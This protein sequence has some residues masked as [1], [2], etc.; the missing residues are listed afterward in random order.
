[1]LD[2]Y[3]LVFLTEI[4]TS[5]KIS[6]TGFSIIQHSAKKGHRGGVAFLI[7]PSLTKFISKIDRSYENVI[8][9]E[10][11]IMPNIVFVGCYIT[12][13]DSPYYDAAVFGYLQG[14][15]K[16]DGSKQFFIL[17]D[18]NSRVGTPTSLKCDD[19]YLQYVGCEDPNLN[20][21]GT[22]ILRLCEE[23]ELAVINNL[24][25]GDVH[26]KSNLSFRKKNN[27]ISEPDLLLVSNKSLDLLSS[28]RMLQYFEE[29][30]LY[31]D[32]GLLEAQINVDKLKI[33]TKLL[34][35]RANNLGQSLHERRQIKID[36]S[37]RLSECNR[38]NVVSYFMQNNPPNLVGTECIETV[39]NNFT[40]EVMEVLKKNR[41]RRVIEPS[42]W[43][44][45]AKW[46]RLLEGNDPKSIWKAINWEGDIN[47]TSTESPSDEEFRVHFEELLNPPN[48]HDDVIDVSDM[49]YIPILDDPITEKEVVE[50]ASECKESKSYIGITP[51]IFKVMPAL[52]ITF[53]TQMLNLIF[54]S[55]DLSYPIKWCFNKFIVLFKKGVRLNC[56]NYRGLSIGDSVSKLYAKIMSKRL[57]LWMFIDKCQ[58]GGQAL[59]GCLEHILAL[60]LIIDYAKNEK[61]KLFIV[62]VDFSKAYDRVPRK[63]LFDILKRLG[64]GRRFLGA[65]I[66]VYKK[67]VNILNSEYIRSTIGVKQGGPM[68]CLLFVIYL[69]VLAL[70]LKGVG[71]D[72]FLLDV[73]A[74]ML[75]DDT[76]LLAGSRKSMIK[77]FTILMKFCKKYGMLVNEI[78]TKLMVINGTK[79]D[80]EQF[81][82]ESVVVKHTISYIYLGSPFTE[83]GKIKDVIQ[84]HIKTRTADVNKFKIF[85]KKNET[86][87]YMYKRTVLLAMII[88]GLLYGCE[89]WLTAQSKDVEKLY[90]G[91]VKSL[92]GVRETTR[93]DTVLIEAGMQTIKDLIRTRTAAFVKKELLN[94]EGEDVTPLV[95]IFRICEGKNT[96]GYR[97][98]KDLLT[99][100]DIINNNDTS[101]LLRNF[102]N[103]TGT[104]AV[105][106]RSINP[107]LRVHPVYTT[108][109]YVS[110]RARLT[111]TKFRL[112]SHSLK[113]E[114]GRWS[115]INHEDRLCDCGEAVEDEFH[116]L[117]SCAKTED[118]RRKFG[119]DV[120]LYENVGAMMDT[121]DVKVLV[122]FVDCCMDKFK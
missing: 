120:R 62:F 92:L 38:E 40:S 81:T 44:N 78:K 119:I 32:H 1:M 91:A 47:E 45:E 35:E 65:L 53:I 93:T 7:K 89:T 117:F 33:S 67:T 26:F 49:P 106:Y 55:N 4:K 60:R 73:H 36:K 109:D 61:K 25:Y 87:P 113:V 115:R 39:V 107:N 57:Y 22:S 23:N 2:K 5:L 96:K 63:T 56:G 59:R 80:R 42:E 90:I 101:S 97:Y 54:C 17:G 71:N 85:S 99:P 75:M 20:L 68:S 122:V 86:M 8:L 118:V 41:V 51:A 9:M 21:N 48:Q 102:A 121:L 95:K 15:M 77:K 66:S 24:K 16:R 83:N 82:V 114:T 108:K 46:K 31:S 94:V 112:S 76:V 19:S 72:S 105:T 100:I 103:E 111:F 69:N 88:A 34:K 79:A 18:L 14:L 11:S 98:I 70:M 13:S 30:H 6:C 116:V 50:S 74:L 37:V 28:F 58:A 110:E 64:C 3:S 12:P 10:L 43:G 104:K 29:K 27:W 52:W 84:L